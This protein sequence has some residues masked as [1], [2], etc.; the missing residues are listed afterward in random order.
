M[1]PFASEIREEQTITEGKRRQSKHYKIASQ[2][3]KKLTS[4]HTEKI[5]VRSQVGD[6][7]VQNPITVEL[8]P[9]QVCDSPPSSPN[10]VSHT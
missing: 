4:R 1:K 9:E 7:S 2:P 3:R 5:Y 8:F 10:P 6:M